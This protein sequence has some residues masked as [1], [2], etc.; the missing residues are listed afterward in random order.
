MEHQIP[1]K[2]EFIKDNNISNKV[3]KVIDLPSD[4]EE[5]LEQL[6]V[7]FDIDVKN[8]KNDY[9]I[10]YNDDEDTINVA[11]Q[12]DFINMVE[13]F[14]E[15]TNKG[16]RFK[17]T[18]IRNDLSVSKSSKLIK[19]EFIKKSKENNIKSS[20]NAINDNNKINQQDS[21]NFL[22]HKD[23]IS[24]TNVDDNCEINYNTNMKGGKENNRYKNDINKIEANIEVIDVD[25]KKSD[26]L[27]ESNRPRLDKINRDNNLMSYSNSNINTIIEDNKEEKS[28]YEVPAQLGNINVNKNK[29]NNYDDESNIENN[30][31]E[32]KCKA[33]IYDN[34]NYNEINSNFGNHAGNNNENNN[35]FLKQMDLNKN[36]SFNNDKIDNSEKQNIHSND[37]SNQI[38]FE[39]KEEDYGNIINQELELNKKSQLLLRDIESLREK[40]IVEKKLE[41]AEAIKK[42][43]K[44]FMLKGNDIRKE[45][46]AVPIIPSTAG[47]NINTNNN[48]IYQEKIL[49]NLN[50]FQNNGIEN[51]LGIPSI[52]SNN[53]NA[54]NDNNINYVNNPQVKN[55]SINQEN[56]NSS[57]KKEIKLSYDENNYFGIMDFKKYIANDI[58]IYTEKRV[59]DFKNSLINELLN[60]VDENVKV[61]ENKLKSTIRKN[62]NPNQNT[63]VSNNNENINI[64]Q[65]TN[66]KENIY[67]NYNTNNQ[68]QLSNEKINIFQNKSLNFKY[69]DYLE[70]IHKIDNNKV[71]ELG[72]NFK[73]INNDVSNNGIFFNNNVNNQTN[74]Q[75][76]PQICNINA[77]NDKEI[78]VKPNSNLNIYKSNSLDNEIKNIANIDLSEIFYINKDNFNFHFQQFNKLDKDRLYENSIT[79][80]NISKFDIN[81]DKTILTSDFIIN[82]CKNPNNFEYSHSMQ[83]DNP[84]IKPNDVFTIKVVINPFGTSKKERINTLSVVLYLNN[85]QNAFSKPLYLPITIKYEKYKSNNY[86]EN[87][88]WN[89]ELEKYR[90]KIESIK[91]VLGSDNNYSD[92]EIFQNLRKQNY[93]VEATLNELFSK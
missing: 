46:N 55:N 21:A 89:P 39:A 30:Y 51:N 75:N 7:L 14:G 52:N 41:I 81:F 32:E 3:I 68:Q 12:E 38:F 76:Q 80:K 78:E 56:N 57:N 1:V 49:P 34:N 31:N 88:N 13:I 19:Q 4:Y 16:K 48:N 92:E 22:D 74:N 79:L 29:I 84:L 33:N 63:N 43:M 66:T 72:N 82:D 27:I 18:M 44:K 47:T 86:K 23:L 35:N 15:E 70:K 62:R 71:P 11:S 53:N 45:E 40:E 59:E 20:E 8:I 2:I 90:E 83:L 5:F 69:P 60:I 17:I 54:F 67:S 85:R 73:N 93:N 36:I 64:N 6:K 58:K 25:I 50:N 91:E 10:N 28:N 9:L 77:I 42:N 65:L 87:K 37:N 61:Y 26:H 24:D